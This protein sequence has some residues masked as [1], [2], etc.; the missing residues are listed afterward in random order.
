M[1]SLHSHVKHG[2]EWVGIDRGVPSSDLPEAGHLAP[3]AFSRTALLTPQGHSVAGLGGCV[4]AGGV[5]QCHQPT[6]E[7]SGRSE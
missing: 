4:H 5:G 3:C 7:L 2:G 1:H 6:M